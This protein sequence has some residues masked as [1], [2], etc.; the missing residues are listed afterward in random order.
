MNIYWKCITSQR[1]DMTVICLDNWQVGLYVI[2]SSPIAVLSHRPMPSLLCHVRPSHPSVMS[3][4]HVRP[5]RLSFSSVR[6]SVTSIP[7]SKKVRKF[8]LFVCYCLHSNFVR[9]WNGEMAG[10][11][12]TLIFQLISFLSS[13]YNIYISIYLSKICISYILSIYYNDVCLSVSLP[14]SYRQ[15][16]LLMV[17]L[18]VRLKSKLRKADI[19]FFF[20]QK[21]RRFSKSSV[22]ICIQV[23]ALSCSFIWLIVWDM[24]L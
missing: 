7:N 15:L 24:N 18:M 2:I 14:I 12:I 8:A 9:E 4:H 11:H 6:L 16:Y 13:I 21:Y 22:E 5:S 1:A 19:C 17:C 23:N 3:I 20:L 10:I